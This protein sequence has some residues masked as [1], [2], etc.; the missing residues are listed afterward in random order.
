MKRTA[1]HGWCGAILALLMVTLAPPTRAEDV[2]TAFAGGFG[3]LSVVGLES[4]DGV[5]TP[6]D[7]ARYRRIFALQEDGRWQEAAA[8]IA[9]LTDNR[10]M[11][12]V[13]AQKYLHPTKYRSKFKELRAWMA[14]Y[15][16]HPQARR[17]YRLAVHRMPAGAGRPH[18]PIV[19]KAAVAGEK[20][21]VKPADQ[22]ARR[23]SRAERRRARQISAEIR[24]R[25]RR[26][27]PTGARDVLAKSESHRLLSP[28]QFDEARRDIAR[29]YFRAGKDLEAL[30]SADR[31]ADNTG[32]AVPLAHWWGGL[33]AWRLGRMDDAQRHFASLALSETADGWNVA[34]GAYWAGRAAMIAQRPDLISQFHAIGARHPFTFY[35]LLSRRALGLD[36]GYDWTLPGITQPAVS[37]IAA[38]QYGARALALL[39]IGQE[40]EAELELL[41]LAGATPNLRPSIRGLAVRTNMPALS[42]KLAVSDNESPTAALYPLPGW[43][44]LSGFDIDRALIFAFIRQESAFNVRAKSPAGARGLMQLMPRTA[45]FVA[46]ERSLHGNGKHR[47]FDP[48]FNMDLGQRYLGI[49]LNESVVGGDLFRLATAY[50]AGP[51]NL[52]RWQRSMGHGNDPLLFIETVPSRETRLFIERVLTNFWVYRDRMGQPTPT[53]DAVVQG[54][55]PTYEGLDREAALEGNA[56]Y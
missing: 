56:L 33:A 22:P 32:D 4:V 51:G 45:S 46:R 19:A 50:N 27:W 28:V 36:V 29:G 9:V 7:E 11:G 55:W 25:V 49:L 47:L 10:L 26:G 8:E 3:A 41:S 48:E 1:V 6:Q 34:A 14:D 15:A 20:N 24:R 43:T 39:Q 5:L 42:F 23:L 37:A 21:A 53:L 31:A 38:T 40:R 17:I 18:S 35:G 44:P 13:L 54:N 12:H 2:A 16:D 30:Q 52:G